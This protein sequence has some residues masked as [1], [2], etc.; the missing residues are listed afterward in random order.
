M[1]C[2]VSPETKYEALRP[3]P[4]LVGVQ[5]EE[6]L[7]LADHLC[8]LKHVHRQGQAQCQKV[9]WEVSGGKSNSRQTAG[10]EQVLERNKPVP[11]EAKATIR[12]LV[13][14]NSMLQGR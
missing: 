12:Q 5:P 13:P 1:H 6:F 14:G 2:E 7:T 8:S 4:C 11:S 9:G 3:A 10:P